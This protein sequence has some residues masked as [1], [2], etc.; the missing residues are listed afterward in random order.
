[1]SAAP[2]VRPA[3]PRDAAL[4]VRTRFVSARVHR[5]TLVL[6]VVAALLLAALAL[7]ALCLGDLPLAPGDVLAALT[8]NGNGIAATVVL[9]WRLPHVLA[10][11]VFGA[12][13]GASG[14]IFQSLTRNPLAS[15]DIIGLSAGSYAGGLIVIIVFGAAAGSLPVSAGAVVGGLATAAVVYALSYRRGIQ[16][17]RLII[18]GIGVAAMLQATS[19]YLLLR[20]KLEVA[21]I[22]SVWGAGS[23]SSVGWGQFT[24]GAIT[25][26]VVF[27]V[28]I[29]IGS[30]LRQLELG[31]DAAKALGSRVERARLALV[32]CGVALTAVVTACAGPIA[33]VA[34]AAPQIARRITRSPGTAL[35]P[36]ALAGALVLLA[37]DLVAQHALPA[38]L[39]VGIVTVV[40]GGAYLIWLLVHENRR[41]P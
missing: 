32:V 5:R 10:A 2:A 1:M 24:T 15:P 16:G 37:S 29:G 28:L 39:P 35:V 21:M 20:A 36:S 6:C 7:A 31:D 41:R 13:L 4:V 26:A 18:I 38:R 34:L 27:A 12:A 11:V 23:L 19:T 14:A 3:P 9:E 25:I 17:F 33:F 40:V 30:S 22:A 8:G